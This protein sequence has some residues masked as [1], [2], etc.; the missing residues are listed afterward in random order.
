MSCPKKVNCCSIDFTI[1]E[2]QLCFGIDNSTLSFDADLGYLIGGA[3]SYTPLTDKPQ[4]NYKTLQSGNNTL[5]YLDIQ[6][7][8]NDITEQ[9]I[10]NMLYGG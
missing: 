6:E 2:Q 10:D 7:T 9:D 5:E 3:T 8:I 4:I 1:E